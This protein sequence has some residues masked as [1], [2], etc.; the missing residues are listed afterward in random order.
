[1]HLLLFITL[2][3]IVFRSSSTVI[4]VGSCFCLLSLHLLT[5]NSGGLELSKSEDNILGNF[6]L[7]NGVALNK[8]K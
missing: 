7:W 2:V 8:Q 5:I 1:M 4:S 3:Q 6:Y